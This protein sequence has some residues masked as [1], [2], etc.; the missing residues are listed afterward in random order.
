MREARRGKAKQGKARQKGFKLAYTEFVHQTQPRCD[1]NRSPLHLMYQAV[2]LTAR[3]CRLPVCVACGGSG[4]PPGLPE[5]VLALGGQA[6]MMRSKSSAAA[7]GAQS[8]AATL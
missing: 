2:A 4:S 5:Y 7:G 6:G 8:A 1:A 3:H